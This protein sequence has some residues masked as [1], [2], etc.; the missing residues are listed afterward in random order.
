VLS[1]AHLVDAFQHGAEAEAHGPILFLILALPTAGAAARLLRTAFEFA[2]NRQRFIVTEAELNRARG[3][4][5]AAV[6]PLAIA[7]AMARA[8][9]ALQNEHRAW[10]LLMAEAEWF[11]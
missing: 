6:G 1:V 11:G 3:N 7:E 9:Y 5:E 10:L 8:E 4:L 2:R